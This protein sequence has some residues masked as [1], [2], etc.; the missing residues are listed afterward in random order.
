MGFSRPHE[1]RPFFA[2]A[3]PKK[4]HVPSGNSKGYLPPFMKVQKFPKILVP[5]QEEC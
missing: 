5:T 1:M 2:V 3:F 4:F